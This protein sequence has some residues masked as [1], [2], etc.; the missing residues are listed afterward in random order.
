MIDSPQK[1]LMP[2][3]SPASGDEFSD[4]AIPRRMWEHIVRWSESMSQAAQMIVVDNRPPD[5]AS[6]HVVVRYS[7]HAGDPPYGL[8]EDEIG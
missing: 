8:I 2:E 6:S 1:N 4:P 5:L 7:G 3:G